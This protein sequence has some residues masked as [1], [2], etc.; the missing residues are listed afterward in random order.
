[1]KR[2][3]PNVVFKKFGTF[4]LNET[5]TKMLRGDTKSIVLYSVN[6]ISIL[7]QLIGKQIIVFWDGGN[8]WSFFRIYV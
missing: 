3:F 6:V 8:I 5:I 1:L 4:L 2:T 7:L